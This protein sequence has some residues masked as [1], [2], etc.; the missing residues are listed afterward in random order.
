MAQLIALKLWCNRRGISRIVV[1]PRNHI[2]EHEQKAYQE[3]YDL[4]ATWIGDNNRQT[5]LADL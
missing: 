2:E 1:H 3:I 4:K 5:R